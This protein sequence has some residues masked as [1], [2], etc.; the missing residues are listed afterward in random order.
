MNLYQTNCKK[1]FREAYENRYTWP[2]KFNGYKGKCI[3][4][5]KNKI[6]E[7]NFSV[8]K[9]FKPEIK[10]IS[11]EEIVKAIGSQ[12]FEVVIHRVKRSFDESHS[13]ND[14]Q[15]EAITENGIEMIVSGKNEGDKYRVKDRKINMVY[16][17][18]HGIIIQ[19][20]VEQFIDT[21][22]GLLSQ[23]YS[24]RELNQQTLEAKSQKFNYEDQFVEIENNIWV[25]S[26]RT[27]KYL[28]DIGEEK[29]DKF[30]FEE[31]SLLK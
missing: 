22:N 5:N 10:N 4:K 25:L 27:I 13:K 14:F 29:I 24:S 31:M 17:K 15:L 19:I 9:N 11:N 8:G 3:F 12:L 18:I 16:R 6:I 7:G 28:N 30:I 20:F 21:G 23:K 26:S 1:I 2:V